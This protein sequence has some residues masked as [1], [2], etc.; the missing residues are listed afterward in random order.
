[1]ENQN[2]NKTNSNLGVSL[3]TGCGTSLAAFIVPA[4]LIYALD[5]WL[6]PGESVFFIL[7]ICGL[8]VGILMAVVAAIAG[9]VAVYRAIQPR[10][11]AFGLLSWAGISIL[12]NV[13]VSGLGQL[14]EN[15]VQPLA[16]STTEM[17]NSFSIIRLIDLIML[18]V[19]DLLAIVVG[20]LVY[21]RQKSKLNQA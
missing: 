17:L 16:T 18:L 7:M 2:I 4:V 12:V 1:M 9:G 8:G 20:W 14:A 15:Y 13:A 19:V 5:T 10:P 21:R 3:L 11:L 6:L